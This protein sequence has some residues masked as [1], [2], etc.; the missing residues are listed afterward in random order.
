MRLHSAQR[1][2]NSYKVRM[3]L[4]LLGSSCE[5]VDY[6]TRGGETH[7]PNFLENVNPD[8]RVPVLELEDGTMLPESGAILYYLGEGTPYL[9]EKRSERAQ[10]LR[11]MFFEQYS[12][13]PN[14]SRPRLWRT[15][16]VEMTSQRR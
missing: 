13:L 8:G 10:A 15:W 14:L 5:I 9:P 1:S 16:G 3:L 4:G 11:W 12:L 7:A 2:G 6:D